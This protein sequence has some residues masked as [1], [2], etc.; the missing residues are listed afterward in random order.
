M[1]ETI[2]QNMT[3]IVLSCALINRAPRGVQ[4]LMGWGMRIGQGDW[5]QL[6][7]SQPRTNY[8]SHM[9]ASLNY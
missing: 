8:L 2:L 9:D 7:P 3:Y 5:M 1:F 6:K 4:T